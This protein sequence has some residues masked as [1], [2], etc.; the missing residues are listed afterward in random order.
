[1]TQTEEA[2]RDYIRGEFLRDQ[3][4][5]ELPSDEPLIQ[6][7]VID[8][9]GIFLLIGFLEEHFEIKVEPQDVVLEN[10]ETIDAITSL[11]N[12]RRPTA[13]RTATE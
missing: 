1:V 8:S 6:A 4:E 5:S 9:L 11:V 3:P 13:P 2:I 12:A 7:G 10:F